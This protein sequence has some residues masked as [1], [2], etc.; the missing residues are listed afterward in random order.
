MLN[1]AVKRKISR[2]EISVLMPTYNRVK[3]IQPAIRSILE[4]THKNLQ[5]I[6]YDDGSTDTTHKVISNIKDKRIKYIRNKENKGCAYARNQLLA[7][8]DTEIACW[9][10]SD[11]ISHVKRLEI[12]YEAMRLGKHHMTACRF[13][14]FV[15]MKKEAYKDK[16]KCGSGKFAHA[17]VMFKTQDVLNVGLKKSVGGSD[18][19]WLRNMKEKFG[20][21]HSVPEVLYFVRRHNNR[22][23]V[24]KRSPGKNPEWHARM[25]KYR[26][27]K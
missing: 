15:R 22:V 21:C 11:D 20:K 25:M 17:S 6:I 12:Q 5:L 27:G 14:F 23:G 19:T 4:Q 3:L 7:A 24:W 16:P 10:D 9:M 13:Q 2:P 8:C 26:N 18:A 1:K